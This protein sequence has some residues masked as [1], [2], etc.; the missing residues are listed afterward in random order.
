[1]LATFDSLNRCGRAGSLFKLLSNVCADWIDDDGAERGFRR[2][3][4]PGGFLTL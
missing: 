2:P 4:G 1:L 3:G